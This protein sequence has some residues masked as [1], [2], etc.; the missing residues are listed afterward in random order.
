M[1]T[2]DHTNG[3][4][5]RLVQSR[6]Q[7]TE[8]RRRRGFWE[9]DEGRAKG[10]GKDELREKSIHSLRLPHNPLRAPKSD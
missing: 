1:P 10:Y 9:G 4:W 6:F 2:N 7:A 3:E 8:E 5:S